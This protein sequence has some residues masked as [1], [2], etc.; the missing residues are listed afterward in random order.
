MAAFRPVDDSTV[1][2]TVSSS[3]ARL[4]LGSGADERSARIANIGD[5]WVYVRFGY[6]DVEA[7]QNDIPI[8]PNWVEVFGIEDATHVA[9]ITD[10][11]PGANTLRVTPGE[12]E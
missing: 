5:E 8:P 3:S 1:S 7:D 6:A 9:A 11:S 2:M 10:S 4:D 12:G